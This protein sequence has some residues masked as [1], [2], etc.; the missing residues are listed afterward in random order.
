MRCPKCNKE[1]SNFATI[2]PNCGYLF[3]VHKNNISSRLSCS[4]NGIITDNPILDSEADIL[5]EEEAKLFKGKWTI[6][7]CVFPKE[8]ENGW[9]CTCGQVNSSTNKICTQC[10]A[11]KEWLFKNISKEM[12]A[13]ILA[14]KEKK[15][16]QK[17]KNIRVCKFLL[18]SFVVLG[19]LVLFFIKYQTTG[20]RGLIKDVRECCQTQDWDGALTAIAQ[21]TEKYPNA[22]ES[23]EAIRITLQAIVD[24]GLWER[25]IQLKEQ[26]EKI[27]PK[28]NSFKEINDLFTISAKDIFADLQVASDNKD[29]A[30]VIEYKDILATL[31]SNDQIMQEAERLADIA[32]EERRKEFLNKP[33]S[34][35]SM[36][37]YQS[38]SSTTSGP[39]DDDYFAP[40]KERDAW[41]CAQD[42]VNSNLKVPSTANFCT[43][44][45]ADITWDGGSDYTVSGYVDAENAFGSMVRTYFTVTLT[46]TEDG[47]KNGSVTF[48]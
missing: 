37:S 6:T 42:I 30:A 26:A 13:T 14:E 48:K 11:E 24:R 33:V 2:C 16:K 38:N 23:S 10:H 5:S 22:E 41:I 44:P 43:Y 40:N 1:I 27:N 47:Y 20:E 29:W 7:P 28:E 21:L 9:I 25:I 45:S 36:P 3:Q 15:Q 19:V 32:Y 39:K 12:A 34:P 18:L 35:Q 46:L 4:G 31:S 8:T 17:Q